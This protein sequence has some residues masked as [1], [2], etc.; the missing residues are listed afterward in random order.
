MTSMRIV[1]AAAVFLGATTMAFAQAQRLCPPGA[2]TQ[3]DCYGQPY[4]GTAGAR[5]TCGHVGYRHHHRHV[6][7]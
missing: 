4:S 2:P 1:V 5:C 7:Q 6:W 3:G